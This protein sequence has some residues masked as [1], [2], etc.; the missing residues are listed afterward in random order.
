[1][2]D[3]RRSHDRRRDASRGSS[4]GRRTSDQPPR[5]YT[6]VLA[7]DVPELRRL[8][9]QILHWSARFTVVAEAADGTEAIALAEEHEP[10]ILL[11]DISM[12]VMDGMEALPRI[13]AVSP[14][15]KV[16]VL[17]G[18]EA[19]RLEQT[20]LEIGAAAYIEKG[21][22]PALLITALLDVVDG[23]R[24]ERP[25]PVPAPAPPHLSDTATLQDISAEEMMSLVAHEIRNPLAVIQG[26]G[27]ELSSRWDTM[28]DEL[29]LDSVRRMT[30][31]ARYLNTVV[32]N[33]MFM[34][35]LESGEYPFVPAVEEI[36][37]LMEA[38]R[39]ELMDL[40]RGHPLE[41]EV[42]PGLPAVNI[43]MMC[44][45]QVLTNLVVNAAKFSPA[46]EP[47]T[48]TVERSQ[49]GV[50]ISVTDRGPG[51]PPERRDAVFEKFTRLEE[52]GSGIGLG[53]FISRALM[54]T[55]GGD[56]W[57]AEGGPGATLSCLLPETV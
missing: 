7:D 14:R 13:R 40:A 33:L 15:T 30:E 51:I 57:V 2:N 29:K 46:K 38:L 24:D 21:V 16:V 22:P 28:T 23:N 27:T 52:G 55:M 5:T 35:K 45:R 26:F 8:L 49:D 43:D 54:T 44:I 47:I 34:R 50:V 41:I 36:D 48:V 10:D 6:V 42:A 37:P 12:P 4:S 39:D 32:N 17:S 25:P 3:D 53:L 56:L 19:E 31:R 9:R 1:M 20:A 11:L 18:F